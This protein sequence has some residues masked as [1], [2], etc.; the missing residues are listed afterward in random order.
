MG[1]TLD[2]W[3]LKKIDLESATQTVAEVHLLLSSQMWEIARVTSIRLVLF[4]MSGD[5]ANTDVSSRL[6]AVSGM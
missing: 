1:K 5:V 2:S 4:T 3:Q 6:I